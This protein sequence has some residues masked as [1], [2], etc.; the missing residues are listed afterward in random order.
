MHFWKDCGTAK[1]FLPHTNTHAPSRPHTNYTNSNSSLHS[2][3]ARTI[4]IVGW[5][6]TSW[7]KW[8]WQNT[9]V[10][11]CLPPSLPHIPTYILSSPHPPYCK[12]I[13]LFLTPIPLSLFAYIIRLIEK[14]CRDE[15]IWHNF[16]TALKPTAEEAANS[17]QLFFTIAA[18]FK[19]CRTMDVV[20]VEVL[21]KKF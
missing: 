5:F 10:H 8:K 3:D 7:S 20:T 11:F 15:Q 14:D 12:T 19:K 17:E 21:K 4:Q 1:Y 16:T 13:P 2:D 18:F 9:S 6:I